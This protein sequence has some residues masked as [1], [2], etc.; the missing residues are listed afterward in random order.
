VEVDDAGILLDV[1]DDAAF[2][3]L[4]HHPS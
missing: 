4:S 2:R 3:R 1:D